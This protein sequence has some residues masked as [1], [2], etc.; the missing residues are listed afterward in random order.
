MDIP[1]PVTNA[2]LPRNVA[3]RLAG[4]DVD[5]TKGVD[6]MMRSDEMIRNGMKAVLVME[7]YWFSCLRQ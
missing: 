4:T 7:F 6:M 5:L 3:I 2:T 1:A